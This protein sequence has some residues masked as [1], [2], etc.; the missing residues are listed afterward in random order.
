MS[1]NVTLNKKLPEQGVYDQ[2]LGGH[3]V[4]R[5]Q[6]KLYPRSGAG[7]FSPTGQNVIQ[8][9]LPSHG[10]IDT[11]R[12]YMDY[13]LE[14]SC[15]IS[16]LRRTFNT[17]IYKGNVTT[18]PNALAAY[19]NNVLADN[20]A[21]APT[22]TGVAAGHIQPPALFANSGSVLEDPCAY[23]LGGYNGSSASPFRLF[24][25]LYDGEPIEYIDNYNGLVAMLTMNISDSYRRSALGHMQ[26][27]SPR[28]SKEMILSALSRGDSR[29][30]DKYTPVLSTV[31]RTAAGATVSNLSEK[32]G[33]NSQR[34]IP[35]GTQ[36]STIKTANNGIVTTQYKNIMHL[37]IS[38]VMGN[39]KLLPIK[40]LGNLDMEFQLASVEQTLQVASSQACN[41]YVSTHVGAVAVGTNHLEFKTN[42]PSNT[43][44]G[45]NYYWYNFMDYRPSEHL[46]KTLI[47][48]VMFHNIIAGT[49]GTYLSDAFLS[50]IKY[51]ISDPVYNL[52]I[53][54][55]SE[56]YDGA[57]ADALTRGVTYSYETYTAT[58]APVQGNGIVHIP[59]SKTSIKAIFSGF[60]NTDVTGSLL[61]NAW[62]FFNPDLEEYQ[63]KFGGKLVPLEPLKVKNDKGL[64][65]L[66]MYLKAVNMHYNPL[67][68]FAYGWSKSNPSFGD[69][70]NATNISGLDSSVTFGM[71][72]ATEAGP[73]TWC[74]GSGSS[75]QGSDLID[76]LGQFPSTA[77]PTSATAT[78]PDFLSMFGSNDLYG[79]LAADIR[80]PH[81]DTLKN[82]A[83]TTWT[84][85]VGAFCIGLDLETEQ[86]A[87]SG[88]NTAGSTAQLQW[89]FK[90]DSA[91]SRTIPHSATTLYTWILHDK[92]LRF[93]PFGRASV[94]VD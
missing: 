2:L 78:N 81:A 93:E 56:A 44:F 36:A 63:C 24:R 14:V 10:Y 39:S 42:T 4:N 17:S 19:D 23:I 88:I 48:Q 83:L 90:F 25:L 38:G 89:S 15:D 9:R 33:W 64:M 67:A 94:I 34:T 65:S 69:S 70:S 66:M 85:H 8:F 76:M 82:V 13:T 5:K 46:A 31:G 49:A 87:M 61:T 21:F 62:Q 41:K 80:K 55:M 79:T 28:G 43:P 72:G 30:L 51:Q 6:A 7:P 86:D 1:Y 22:T 59:V 47:Q 52:E 53:V 58:N 57:F 54:Y 12:S 40:Y 84:Y 91:A 11:L 18:I 37:P 3:I 74:G 45:A 16:S 77:A 68:G 29:A 75:A 60:I 26:F 73:A 35:A 92:A 27:L 32:R 20:Q 71:L 50:T